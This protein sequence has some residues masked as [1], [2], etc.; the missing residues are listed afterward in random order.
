MTD[1]EKA[2]KANEKFYEVFNKQ[3][4][5]LMSQVWMDDDSITCIHPGWDV[6]HGVETVMRS[7]KGIFQNSAPLDIRLSE[8]TATVS[9]DL[10][11]VSCYENLYVISPDGV[12]TSSV[13]A[14][15]MF[16]KVKGEWKMVLHHASPIPSKETVKLDPD[17]R[18]DN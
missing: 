3:D 16:Q 12:M 7:W 6:L 9:K 2:L 13:Y 8:V 11:W 18:R 15:N 14:T 17:Q 5:D 4:V 10:V 1:E